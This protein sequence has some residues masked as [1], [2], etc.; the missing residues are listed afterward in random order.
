MLRIGSKQKQED[1]GILTEK[2]P[3]MQCHSSERGGNALENGEVI[4]VKKQT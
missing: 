2:E 4:R 3:S 1:V